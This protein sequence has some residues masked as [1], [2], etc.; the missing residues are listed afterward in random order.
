MRSLSEKRSE[1]RKISH[2]PEVTIVPFRVVVRIH[3]PLLETNQSPSSYTG[4]S[5]RFW[6]FV[7]PADSGGHFSPL[8]ESMG[9][10]F[11]SPTTSCLLPVDHFGFL[12]TADDPILYKRKVSRIGINLIAGK[13]LVD[14]DD[15]PFFIYRDGCNLL[16]TTQ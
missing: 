14:I 4:C 15:M 2:N 1:T 5:A 10:H 9:K 11:Q 3:S 6:F 7:S 12:T 16:E 13:L 8:S